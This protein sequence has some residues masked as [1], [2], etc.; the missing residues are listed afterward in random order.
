MTKKER[1][2]EL[3]RRV[4][5]LQAQ[6]DAALTRIDELELWRR[7]RLFWPEPAPFYVPWSPQ[8]S[9]IDP[10][11]IQ[12]RWTR[13]TGSGTDVVWPSGMTARR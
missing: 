6:L 9:S 5:G 8:N 7:G 12:T 2:A 11:P 13:C 1:I 4:A 10:E 3:E